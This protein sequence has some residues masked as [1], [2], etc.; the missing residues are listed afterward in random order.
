M[1]ASAFDFVDFISKVGVGIVTGAV[2]AIVTAKV[3]LN[4]FYREKWWEKKH[5]SYNQLIERLFEIKAIY[6]HASDF[7]EAEYNAS[8]HGTPAPIGNVDWEKYHQI[9]AV[10]HRFYVL[11]PI[12][13]SPNSRELL[14]KFFKQDEEVGYSVHEEGYPDFIA[15]ND[16]S[17]AAQ[18]LIDAIVLDAEKEL[19]FK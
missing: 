2:A 4:R 1:P 8:R 5:G 15:Y 7:Y 19:K 10:L 14:D 17:L 12:S 16:M 11:A 18:K 13:L 9:K 3:A 6:D